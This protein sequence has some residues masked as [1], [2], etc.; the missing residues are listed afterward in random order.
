[1]CEHVREWTRKKDELIDN[2]K[3]YNNMVT[4]RGIVGHPLAQRKDA[5]HSLFAWKYN[6]QW[7]PSNVMMYYYYY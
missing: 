6:N 1:M 2:K 4:V 5:V 3:N 7:S